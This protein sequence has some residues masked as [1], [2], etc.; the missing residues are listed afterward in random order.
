MLSS[1]TSNPSISMIHSFIG[2]STGKNFSSQ[3][4]AMGLDVSL[5]A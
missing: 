2:L 4:A 1:S 3:R 5:D